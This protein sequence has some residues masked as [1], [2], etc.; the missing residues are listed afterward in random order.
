MIKNK[1]GSENCPFFV[2]VLC[3]SQS[4][5]DIIDHGI[6]FDT[7]GH[8]EFAVDQ[9]FRLFHVLLFDTAHFADADTFA[10]L[11]EF[12]YHTYKHG[13]VMA[14]HRSAVMFPDSTGAVRIKAF[15]RDIRDTVDETISLISGHYPAH[16]YISIDGH[17]GS[18]RAVNGFKSI[19][20]PV[21]AAFYTDITRIYDPV[22]A[23][24]AID[25][26]FT[27]TKH[28]ITLFKRSKYWG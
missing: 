4:C 13:A 22:N 14:F 19:I 20:Q 17:I 2:L 9:V 16:K 26:K 1:T 7:E 12:L 27:C 3:I 28:H 23:A 24:A 21:F 11:P 25:D 15:A 10:F 5:V 6:P 18:T 8:S